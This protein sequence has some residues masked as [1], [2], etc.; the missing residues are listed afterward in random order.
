MT[1]LPDD[2]EALS[3][4]F[5]LCRHLRNAARQSSGLGVI[6]ARIVIDEFGRPQLWTMPTL[7]RL[8]PRMTADLALREIIEKLTE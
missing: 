3:V 4:W 7:E 1:D 6:T 5:A 8:V 2:Y